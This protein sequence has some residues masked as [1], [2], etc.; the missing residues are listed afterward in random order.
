MW[1]IQ[2]EWL[3]NETKMSL[4]GTIVDL[5]LN[6]TLNDGSKEPPKVFEGEIDFEL[7]H[8]KGKWHDEG[9]ENKQDF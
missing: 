5:V 1:E 7:V 3:E 4:K 6:F 9:S 8:M 2:G